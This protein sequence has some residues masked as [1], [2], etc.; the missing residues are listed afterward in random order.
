MPFKL[1][2]VA[3]LLRKVRMK[4]N[5][6][7]AASAGTA[8]ILYLSPLSIPMET[9]MYS[10]ILIATDGSEL[11]DRG[12]AHGVG[13]AKALG[14]RVTILNA[15][16]PW[17]PIGVDATSVAVSEYGLAEE[18]EKT[19][20]AAGQKILAAA[21]E[22]A[23]SAGVEAKPL[24]VSRKFPADAIIDSAIAENSDLIV[25]ASH[26]RRGVERL[27]LGSQASE[28]LTR[29]TVPVLIVR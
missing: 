29:S 18:F 7:L 21:V 9:Q 13:L 22:T 4:K 8:Q 17:V 11:A 27:L 23:K 24:F 26:G 28:V 14:A 1:L 16:E 25:L 6:A 5:K 19:E 20:A 15:S 3:A 2:G 12:V 10:R